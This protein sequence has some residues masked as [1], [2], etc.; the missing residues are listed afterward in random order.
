MKLPE[1]WARH[2][3]K[4]V[5]TQPTR[6]IRVDGVWTTI[7]EYAEKHGIS[8][9]DSNVKTKSKKQKQINT[10]IEEKGY[11]DMEQTYSSTSVEEHG[12]GDSESTE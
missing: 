6:D 5:W 7:D 11:G 3:V 10:D 4:G 12:D 8:L 9:P 1:Q 2:Y